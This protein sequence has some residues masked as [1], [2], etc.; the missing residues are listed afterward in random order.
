MV[1]YDNDNNIDDL[2]Y[3]LEV[4]LDEDEEEDENN[5]SNGN[6]VKR[7][8]TRV[9]QS[10][11]VQCL[12]STFERSRLIKE[13]GIRHGDLVHEHIVLKILSWKKDKIKEGTLKVDHGTG[14]MTVVLGKEKGGYARGVVIGVTYNRYFDLSRSRQAS[15][16]RI[17]LLQSQLDNERRERQEKELEIQNLSNKMSETEG[18]LTK[19][20]NQLAAQEEQL[21][22]MSTKL[23][24]SDVSPMDIIL[25]NNSADEEGGTLFKCCWM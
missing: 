5:H 23:T 6:V 20:M 16:E 13:H 3:E 25:I 12:K 8:I 14:A 17:A 18:M 24:P 10:I 22:S 11:V 7:G 15:D 9:T 2:G 21:Q 1:N 19:L 4:Y